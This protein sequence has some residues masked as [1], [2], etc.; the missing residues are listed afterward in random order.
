MQQKELK[1]YHKEYR[2]TNLR[3]QKARGLTLEAVIKQDGEK[4]DVGE[5]ERA[6]A[7][8]AAAAAAD[9]LYFNKVKY[10]SII[11]N[12]MGQPLN[13]DDLEDIE[14]NLTGESL[15]VGAVLCTVLCMGIRCYMYL[16]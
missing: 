13:L 8:D 6:A 12:Y 3:R 2:T 16:I 14:K 10:I 9:K 15:F 1:N 4:D 7:A 11:I 5:K